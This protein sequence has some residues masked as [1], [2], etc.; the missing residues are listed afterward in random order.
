MPKGTVARYPG[1]L[2]LGL[3]PREERP[4]RK[5]L[6]TSLL[7]A[8][9]LAG[10]HHSALA[11]DSKPPATAEAPG[12]SDGF[13]LPPFPADAHVSQSTTADGRTLK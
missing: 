10:F 13:Q 11:A 2:G 8:L 4:V 6:Q 5:P 9:L 3:F 1:S 7:A 12:V